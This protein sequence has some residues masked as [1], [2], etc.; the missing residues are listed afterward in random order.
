MVEQLAERGRVRATDN[1]AVPLDGDDPAAHHLHIRHD[2]RVERRRPHPQQLRRQRDQSQRVLADHRGRPVPCSRCRCSTCTGSATACI[3]GCCPAAAC[4]CW[5]AST[6]RRPPNEFLD[7]RPTL[8]FGVPTI[9]VRLLDLPEQTA[10]EIGGIHAAVR[11]R[12]GAAAGSGARRVPS[13]F[14]HTILERYGMT[15]T[16]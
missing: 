15:E 14:G 4:G 8:F 13:R 1:Q 9:Y 10:R 2:R 11:I 16:R 5:S 3:A 6:S 7:F 12:L